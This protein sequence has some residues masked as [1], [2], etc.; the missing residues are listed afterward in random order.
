MLNK[1]K[2]GTL[3]GVPE[4]HTAEALDRSQH[5]IK[6]DLALTGARLE[7]SEHTKFDVKVIDEDA[8]LKLIKDL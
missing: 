2:T 8:W 1:N 6:T 7:L 5:F 3:E 4:D